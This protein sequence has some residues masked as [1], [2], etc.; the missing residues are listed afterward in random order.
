[1]NTIKNLIAQEQ[2]FPA[3]EKEVLPYY[4][5]LAAHLDKKHNQKQAPLLVAINGAQGT[6]KSTMALFLKALLKK[7]GKHT[8]V[9]SIDDLYHT[10]QA[11]RKIA[12][13]IH[14]LLVTRGV[15][16]THDVSLG[17]LVIH[18]LQ[19]AKVGDIVQIPAYDKAVDDRKPQSEWPSVSCPVDIILLEGWC[20]GATPMPDV[21][22]DQP[23]NQLEADED[24]EVV[25]RRYINEQLKQ[26]YQGFFNQF[27]LL[28]MLQA[29]SFDCVKEWRALQEEKLA[30]KMQVRMTDKQTNE[31][32]KVNAP[33]KGLM[34]TNA[35]NRFMMHYERLTK[36]MLEEMPPRADVLITLKQDHSIQSVDY[37]E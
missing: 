26:G 2:L 24:K 15:P 29:P 37:R 35:L 36:H 31:N 14:P 5:N 13:D 22:L 16:G 18:H 23:I 3:F 20:V 12:T 1:M 17:E 34:D 4:E 32:G 9:I 21:D 7:L 8:A 10:Y 28:V 30:R 6:G 33:F 25:W 19:N 27:D 11:R